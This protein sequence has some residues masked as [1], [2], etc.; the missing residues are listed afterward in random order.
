MKRFKINLAIYNTKKT[1]NYASLK[2][3]LIFKLIL[4]GCKNRLINI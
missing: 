1:N 3:Y 2:A 4:G